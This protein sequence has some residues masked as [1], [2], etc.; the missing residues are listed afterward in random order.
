MR[1]ES[2]AARCLQV[3][4]GLTFSSMSAASVHTRPPTGLVLMGLSYKEAH[5]APSYKS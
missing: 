4:L 2:Q 5:T 1:Q 3:Q